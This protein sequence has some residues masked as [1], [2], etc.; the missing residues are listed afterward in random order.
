MKLVK[1]GDLEPGQKFKSTYPGANNIM[2][3]CRTLPGAQ[4]T[5]STPDFLGWAV[6]LSTGDLN[7]WENSYIVCVVE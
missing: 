5:E 4:I 6:E 7:E 3:K 1:F 2:M